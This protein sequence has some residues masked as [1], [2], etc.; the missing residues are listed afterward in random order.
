[1]REHGADG[2][3]NQLVRTGYSLH[4]A[5][6]TA[7]STGLSGCV[8]RGVHPVLL[9]DRAGLGGLDS[10]PLLALAVGHPG[11]SVTV[12]EGAPT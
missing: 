7:V 12:R 10:W 2:Y 4:T 1:M 9:R 8:F 6:L 5:W 3:L 11:E